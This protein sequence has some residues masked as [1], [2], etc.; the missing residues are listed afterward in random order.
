M[1]SSHWSRVC[2]H[3]HFTVNSL[4]THT[5]LRRTPGVGPSCFFYK[6]DTS[7]RQASNTFE[8]VNGQLGSCLCSKKYLE[9]NVS[10]PHDSKLQIFWFCS[11]PPIHRVYTF[12]HLNHKA[13]C[14]HLLVMNVWFYN[15]KVIPLFCYRVPVFAVLYKFNRNVFIANWFNFT[16]LKL[17]ASHCLDSL[18]ARQS[19]P[20][21]KVSTLEI[22]DCIPR[23]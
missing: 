12:T 3:T 15:E 23:P 6:M 1:E 22:V 19:G 9:T 11:V 17:L 5:S 20:L 2:V 4:L 14:E 21:L 16:F 8:T 13:G 10:A 7:L 18:W